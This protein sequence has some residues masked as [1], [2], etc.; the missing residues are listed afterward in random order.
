MRTEPSMAS[1]RWVGRWQR[2]GVPCPADIAPSDE[3]VFHALKKAG[4]SWPMIWW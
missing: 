2:Q 4:S 3:S 1:F